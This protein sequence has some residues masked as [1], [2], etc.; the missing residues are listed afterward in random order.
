LP[1]WSDK[2]EKK[3]EH[4]FFSGA[5]GSPDDPAAGCRITKT[6]SGYLIQITKVENKQIPSYLGT[7]YSTKTSKLTARLVPYTQKSLLGAAAGK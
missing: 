3:E 1:E 5:A 6:D 2:G 4:S 7:G